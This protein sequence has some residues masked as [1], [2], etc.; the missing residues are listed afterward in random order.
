MI[1]LFAAALIAAP[2]PQADYTPAQMGHASI[3]AGMCSTIGWVSS[4][5]QVVAQAEAYLTHHPDKSE[6]EVQAEMMT[7]INAA[8]AEIDAAVAAYRSNRD[9]VVFKA[10]LTGKCNGVARDMPAFL[11]RAA[12]TDQRFEAKMTEL[13][14][15]L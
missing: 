2:A 9:G 11:S 12:D 1:A 15:G 6:T 5:E 3:Y 4:Q 14:P 10:F 8:K 13:L 7:G